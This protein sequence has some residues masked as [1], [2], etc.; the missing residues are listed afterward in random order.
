M[1][2]RSVTGSKVRAMDR[3]FWHASPEW[4]RRSITTVD[5]FRNV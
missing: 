3:A 4:Q 2:R 5:T 1:N